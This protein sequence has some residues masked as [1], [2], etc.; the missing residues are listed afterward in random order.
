MPTIT[1]ARIAIF[2]SLLVLFFGVAIFSSLH[3]HTVSG[4]TNNCSF[5]HIEHQM[6][7]LAEA[8]VVIAP[9]V[10][11]LESEKPVEKV[12]AVT[13]AIHQGRDRA[14]PAHS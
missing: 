3:K 10:F 13:R 14:P 5:N 7:S 9:L 6:V 2:L 1:R 8:A 4:K 11:L 12:E